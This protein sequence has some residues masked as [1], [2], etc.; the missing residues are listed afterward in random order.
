MRNPYERRQALLELDALAALALDLTVDELITIYR[1]GFPVLFQYE[2]DT[3]YDQKGAI[4][5]TINKGLSRVGISRR[6]F[7]Q[8]QQC[9]RQGDDLPSGFNTHGLIPP[10]DRCDREA[11]MRQAYQYFKAKIEADEQADGRQ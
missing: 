4:A 8:W 7:E 3:W 1:V 2:R 6:E 5:F 10:F 9:L 11:D